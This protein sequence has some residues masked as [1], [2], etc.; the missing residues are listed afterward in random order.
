MSYDPYTVAVVIATGAVTVSAVVVGTA[1]AIGIS[2]TVSVHK[3][4]RT[5]ARSTR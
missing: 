4:A 5:L 3:R 1:I 2:R